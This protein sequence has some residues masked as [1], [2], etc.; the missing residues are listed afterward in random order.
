MKSL[1]HQQRAFLGPVMHARHG[2]PETRFSASRL[3]QVL[4]EAT[5]MSPFEAIVLSDDEDRINSLVVDI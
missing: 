1:I 4:D 2:G 5:F 3:T